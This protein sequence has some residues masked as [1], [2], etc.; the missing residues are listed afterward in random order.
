MNKAPLSYRM[1]P[2]NIDQVLGQKHLVGEGGII[3]R[4]VEAGRLSSMILYGPP[5]I[6]KTSIASAIAGSTKYK[7][8]TLNAVTDTKK[9]MQVVAEEGKMSGSVILMLDEI[10]RLDKAKQ[11]FLLPHLESGK[12]VLIGATTSNPY[13]AINQAIRSRTQIFELH[14][15]NDDDIKRVITR[16]LEDKVRALG[17]IDIALDDDA[18][19]HFVK[20]SNGDI[21]SAL[22]GLELAVLSDTKDSIHVTL[23]DAR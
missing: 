23:E 12:I 7:F 18:L 19:E 13:H 21:R 6:G 17:S 14:P 20:A 16:A 3:R 15:L 10:H 5:G 11:D 22:N 2:K 1:R 9:D 8:R 4:M